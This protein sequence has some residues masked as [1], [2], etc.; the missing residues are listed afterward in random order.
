M[1]IKLA[2]RITDVCMLAHTKSSDP[3]VHTYV[4]EVESPELEELL[5]PFLQTWQSGWRTYSI[6]L[7]REFRKGEEPKFPR[8]RPI[9]DRE[10]TKKS[11]RKR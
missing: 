2:V 11:R 9:D 5:A 8:P 10:L 3:E 7:V 4:V 6:S 1:S